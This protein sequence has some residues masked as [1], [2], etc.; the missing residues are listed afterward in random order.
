MVRLFNLIHV[1]LV[2]LAMALLCAMVLI[3]F[4]NVVLRYLFDSGLGWSEEISLL[5]AVWFSFIAMAIGVKQRLH[6]HINLLP[7][8]RIPPRLDA[9][10]WRLRDVV[11]LALGLVFL[12][13]GPVLVSFTM[14]S[15]LPASGLR[16]GWLYLIVPVCA[17]LLIYE[18]VT[19][20]LGV[21]TRDEQIDSYLRGVLSL[22]KALGDGER[23]IPHA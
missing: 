18:A 6:I 4:V 15:I 5:I 16:A 12:R 1:L 7:A 3:I 23:K 19:D 10:L 11:V 17:V 13:W 2:Y 14:R 22:A 9:L 20:L 21:D 8:G